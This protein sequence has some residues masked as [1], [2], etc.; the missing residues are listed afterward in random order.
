MTSLRH[1][2]IPL[3]LQRDC[4]NLIHPVAQVI[5]GVLK[6]AWTIVQA[7]SQVNE[8]MH[9]LLN[10]MKDLCEHTQQYVTSKEHD[11]VVKKIV[12]DISIAVLD[13]ATLINGYAEHQKH[14]SIFQL[15]TFFTSFEQNADKITETLKSLGAK[16]EAISGGSVFTQVHHIS[17]TLHNIGAGVDQLVKNEILSALPCAIGAAATLHDGND[18]GCLPGTRTAVLEAL[19]IW[20][21]GGSTSITLNPISTPLEDHK[22]DLTGTKVLWLQ[23]V[24]GSGKSSIAASVA[25]FFEHSGIY[26]A[27]YRFE[28]AKQGQLKP[29]NLFTTIALQLAAKDPS[30]G[31]RLQE[32]VM[33]TSEL[34]RKSQNPAEQLKLFLVPLLQHISEACHHVVIIIDALDE[35]GGA[36]ERSKV[37]IPLASIAMDLPPSVDILVTTRPEPDIKLALDA[38]PHLANVS[39]VSMHE[40]PNQSTRLDIH[41][42]VTYMLE[43]PL[44]NIKPEQ[45]RVLAEKAHLSFQWAS[46]ACRYIVDRED[47][48]QAVLP[49]MRLR[50]VLESSSTDDNQAGLYTLYTNVMDSQFGQSTQEDLKILKLLLGVL[51]VAQKPISLQAMLQLLSFQLSQHGD[52][53][54]M[55]QAAAVYMGLLSSLITGAQ[56]TSQ[57]TPL[58]PLHSS[59]LDFLQSSKERYYV[60]AEYTHH[61]LTEGCFSVMLHGERGLK[62]NICQLK[63][64]FVPNSTIPSLSAVIQERI[65]EPLIYAC[66]YWTSHLVA[67]KPIS[68]NSLKVV[69]SLLS[70]SK[71]FHWLEV[72]SLTGAAP[73]QG[74]LLVLMQAGSPMKG[75]ESL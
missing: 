40:L 52:I 28:T 38:L 64:S 48:N 57:N 8:H 39:Q 15:P 75:I 55:K 18:H 63:S 47:K 62:F 42:Y 10:S 22:Q 34:E 70:T 13:G 68:N 33:S 58:L 72:M 1:F 36:N 29:S 12:Q 73:L 35:S 54:N 19:Q 16:L 3:R 60:D 71:F 46:T 45:I 69:K 9:I 41:H 43:H 2:L 21:A 59:Y 31:K 27:Y 56:G 50:K 24:A 61:I 25:K 14:K 30:F 23:G 53:E 37:L 51:V 5:V 17:A 4:S 67:S 44:L 26:M 11:S 20:A 7:N 74:L 65:G 6:G 32:L 66:H 49:F